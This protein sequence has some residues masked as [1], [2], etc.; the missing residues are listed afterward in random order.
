M[1]LFWI[2]GTLKIS[3]QQ[4]VAFLRKLAQQRLPFSKHSYQVLRN[5]MRDREFKR[6]RLF[7]KTGWFRAS[8][9]NVGWY[10]GYLEQGWQT[11]LF[12]MNAD[13]DS[14][15]RLPLRQ[16]SVLQA[17]IRLNLLGP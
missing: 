2:D 11:I 4:Q 5:V 16:Q 3:A 1:D 14:P 13:I 15:E 17:L 7:G 9:P 8:T 10:V 6:G 12:A